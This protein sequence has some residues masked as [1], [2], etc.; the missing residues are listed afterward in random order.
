MSGSKRQK[1]NSDDLFKSIEKFK[2]FQINDKIQS[3]EQVK[4]LE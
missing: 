2:D 4:A 1:L 3:I